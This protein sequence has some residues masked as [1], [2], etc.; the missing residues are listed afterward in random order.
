MATLRDH[1]QKLTSL[2]HRSA[3]WEA[4]FAYLDETFITKDGREAK[5]LRVPGCA[6]ELVPESAIEEVLKVISDDYIKVL[7]REVEQLEK[8][9][10]VPY[11][12]GAG[13]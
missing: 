6:E 12:K 5:A 1:L 3:A 2:K 10:L 8:Q 9:N 11:K 13:A 4:A 7:Q